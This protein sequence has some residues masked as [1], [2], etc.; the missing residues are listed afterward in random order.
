MNKK[1]VLKKLNSQYF[2]SFNRFEHVYF[3]MSNFDEK[4]KKFNNHF[5][6]ITSAILTGDPDKVLATW[7]KSWV[8][9]ESTLNEKEKIENEILRKWKD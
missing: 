3:F 8:Y 6:K 5:L 7:R 9:F 2:K 1:E 4:V